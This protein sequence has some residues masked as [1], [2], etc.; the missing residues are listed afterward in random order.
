MNEAN[1]IQKRAEEAQAIERV[2]LATQKVQTAFKSLQSQ[3]PPE[4]SGQPSKLALQVLDAALQE[5][6]DAQMAFDALLN[7]LLD[8]E[9]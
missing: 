2:V 3:F 5:L 6:E 9:R 8:G 1:A 7:D 4:G